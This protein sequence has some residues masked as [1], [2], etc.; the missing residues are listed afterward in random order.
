[1]DKLKWLK[2]K[3]KFY[4][5]CGYG[6]LVVGFV[7][8]LCLLISDIKKGSF[9]NVE[10]GITIGSIIFV[11]A[12]IMAIAGFVAWKY[13]FKKDMDIQSEILHYEALN[14]MANK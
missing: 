7:I 2:L 3:S 1:M 11:L 12:L 13:C 8:W 6:I 14:K 4:K 5:Y 10:L 9:A